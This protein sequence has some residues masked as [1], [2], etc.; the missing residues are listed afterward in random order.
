MNKPRILLLDIET[1]PNI[2][3]VWNLFKNHYISPDQMAQA[4]YTLCWAA[5][6]LDDQKVMFG[7][8]YDQTEKQMLK[9]I[10]T[11]LDEADAVIHYNGK[12]FDIPTLNREFIVNGMFPPSNYKQID[13]FT[14][15]KQQFKLPSYKLDYL[16]KILGVSRKKSNRG[17][18]LWKDCMF[19]KAE[20]WAEMKEYNMQDVV[21]LE[22]VYLKLKPW[23]RGH[24]NYN[25]FNPSSSM[26]CPT[27]GSNHLH[28]RGFSHT[29]T[30]TY[31]RYQCQDCGSWSRNTKSIAP[32]AGQKLTGV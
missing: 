10:H 9:G 5:K 17:M 12:K 6:W 13:L 16:A 18:E 4:G 22:E 21:V 26:S 20:A 23:I 1:A 15:A 27:C 28:R 29:N 24:V 25:L 3:Y 31:Q 7:G 14:T 11:L 32:I 2:A 30:C 19:G 8:L